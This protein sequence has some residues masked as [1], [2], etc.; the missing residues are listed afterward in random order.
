M[1]RYLRVN[2]YDND[3]VNYAILFAQRILWF[4]SACENDFKSNKAFFQ[5]WYAIKFNSN[6]ETFKQ[7]LTDA[8]NYYVKADM[9][10]ERG[11][12]KNEP[13]GLD[14]SFVDDIDSND[15]NRETFYIDISAGMYYV[16]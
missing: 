5:K 6:F 15:W 11:N 14:V 13:L 3:Y 7:C 10:L 16:M 1:K 9:I 8:F 2:F 4:Y 12:F